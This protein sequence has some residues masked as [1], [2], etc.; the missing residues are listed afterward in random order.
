MVT[1]QSVE[2]RVSRESE[3]IRTRLRSIAPGTLLHDGVEQIL[4]AR[5]GALITLGDASGL[6]DICDGGFVINMPLT[7]QRLS[8]LAKMDGAIILSDDASVIRLANVHLVPDS[9]LPTEETGMRHRTAERVSRQTDALVISISQRRNVVSLYFK[10]HKI[11]LEDIE[12]VLAK[13][14]AAL[15]ALHRSRSKLDE[16]LEQLTFLE[17]EDLVTLVDLAE[18]I[19]RFEEVRRMSEEVS[20]FGLQLGTEG[21]LIRMQLAELTSGLEMNYSLVVRD[22]SLDSSRENA[23]KVLK[24]LARKGRESLQEPTGI[25]EALGFAGAMDSAEEIVRP[26]GLRILSQIRSLPGFVIDGVVDTLGPLQ[27]ILSASAE[28]LDRVDGVGVRRA[29][30]ISDGLARMRSRVGSVAASSWCGR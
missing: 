10:G 5:T 7:A 19:A 11:T 21:R 12:V 14:D 28:D 15:Q 30:T 6:A 24:A 8:E 17:L 13:A 23:Q 22:Y 20:R 18:I 9:G 2:Q 16:M 3:A 1:P 29:K 26:R 4:S 27:A 25:L